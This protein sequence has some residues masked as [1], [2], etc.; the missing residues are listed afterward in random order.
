M[1]SW[2]H[3]VVNNIY[4]TVNSSR[5]HAVPGIVMLIAIYPPQ[6]AWSTIQSKHDHGG[7]FV[8]LHRSRCARARALR[9]HGTLP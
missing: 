1:Q 2:L 6:Q 5:I 4:P 7:R 8:G 3:C 9:I